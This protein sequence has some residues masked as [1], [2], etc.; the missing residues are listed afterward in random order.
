MVKT[1]AAAAFALLLLVPGAAGE[2]GTGPP[3]FIK[4]RPDSQLTA[5][6]RPS[7]STDDPDRTYD[8]TIRTYLK[9][10]DHRIARLEQVAV[11]V[12]TT[13]IRVSIRVPK[14][15]RTA[16]AKRAARTHHRRVTVTFVVRATE[17]ASGAVVGPYGIDTYL[18]L[19]H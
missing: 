16:A 9:V 3:V 19:R 10:G 18:L 6:L 14:S 15:A 17:T 13:P 4:L 7:V 12:T 1:A 8:A 11:H 5:V 2:V